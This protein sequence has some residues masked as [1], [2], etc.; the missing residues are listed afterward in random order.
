MLSTKVCMT[1]FSCR[2][3]GWKRSLWARGA[4]VCIC[5]LDP[6][7]AIDL[8][9]ANEMRPPG[10]LRLGMIPA[11]P[12]DSFSPIM[13]KSTPSMVPVCAG[14]SS[15]TGCMARLMGGTMAFQATVLQELVTGGPAVV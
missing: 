2:P 14:N 4:R 3:K 8:I 6:T 7:A 15:G 10:M 5:K 13:M 9:A 1:A 11:V 12:R